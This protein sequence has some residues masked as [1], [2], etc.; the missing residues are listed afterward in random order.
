MASADAAPTDQ[1]QAVYRD[2]AG[3]IDQ[4]LAKLAELL[5]TDLAAFNR[6][7]REKEIPAV[8]V[9][10]KKEKGAADSPPSLEDAGRAP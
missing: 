9:K 6:M 1:T 8:V 2:V 10:P 5:N 3:R 4:Q 7:V